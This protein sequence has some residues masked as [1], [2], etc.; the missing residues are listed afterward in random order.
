M[1]NTNGTNSLARSING[2]ITYDDGAGTLIQNGTIITNTLTAKN[3]SVETITALN[4]I[5]GIVGANGGSIK[6][7]VIDGLNDL[8]MSN[9]CTLFNNEVAGVIYIGCAN[10]TLMYI[11][12][13][14]N[15]NKTLYIGA[16]ASNIYLGGFKYFHNEMNLLDDT[17]DMYIANNQ[18]TGKLNIGTGSNRAGKITI[19]NSTNK[20]VIGNVDIT[21]N[22][23]SLFSSGA[24]TIGTVNT[25]SVAIGTSNTTT[26]NL[27]GGAITSSSSTLDLNTTGALDLTASSSLNGHINIT[28]GAQAICT[29][30]SAVLRL[31]ANLTNVYI[32]TT[33]RVI[34]GLQP[35]N[36]SAITQQ[37]N[38]SPALIVGTSGTG[39]YNTFLDFYTYA[40]IN[41]TYSARII[42][43]SGGLAIANYVAA[44]PLTLSSVQNIN[45]TSSQD[46][47]LTCTA[48]YSVNLSGGGLTFNKGNLTIAN[49]TNGF[50][51]QAG[52]TPNQNLSIAAAS[53]SG[54]P[55]VIT[56]ATAFSAQPFINISLW[57]GTNNSITCGL[58]IS[59]SNI[60]ASGF[61]VNVF[62]TRAAATG[63]QNYG[64]SW[65]AIG[66]Y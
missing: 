5:I 11:G 61:S 16:Y 40:G 28:T 15:A 26:L 57:N 55:F 19:G 44:K 64:I 4:A 30:S 7:N 9:I 22:D 27:T 36:Y 59:T 18:S 37:M 46:I 41:Q 13:N 54:N 66:A 1:S 29:I 50:F 12:Y 35:T 33:D 32:K 58:I 45:L 24:L 38:N 10:T 49:Y 25:T 60:S 23:I 47:N 63:T 39:P 17:L 65:S 31:E 52:Q 8:S 56:F 43:N 20:N 53:L 3:L 14:T 6:C 48:G 42:N 62:N 34:M 21:G 51:I 2:I